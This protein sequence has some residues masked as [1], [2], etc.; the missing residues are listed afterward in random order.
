MA[1]ENLNQFTGS[2][3]YYRNGMNRNFIYTDGVKYVAE[4]GGAYWLV[5]DIAIA[6]AFDPKLKEEGFQSWILTKEE[7]DS[8][9]LTADD[10]N[11]NILYSKKI[12]FT[13]F[14]LDEIKFYVV[15]A[16]E[17]GKNTIMLMLPSEY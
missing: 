16:L 2:E 9:R 1:L 5:D 11:G 4:E 15:D 10:G 13:D 7:N 3:N 8:A 17:F 6:N 14:P 12:D